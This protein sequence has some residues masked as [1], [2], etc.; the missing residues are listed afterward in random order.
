MTAP[1]FGRR[2]KAREL[3]LQALYLMDMR[4]LD[5]RQAIALVL[6]VEERVPDD[7]LVFFRRLVEG[8]EEHLAE[9]DA[10]IAGRLENWAIERLSTVDR[11]ILRLA[12]EEILRH[13]DIPPLVSVNEAIEIAKKYGDEKSGG[14]INGILDTFLR[15]ED[16]LSEN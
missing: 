14:F 4:R 2:R 6:E 11:N 15:P 7:V 9:I 12:V 3:A 1:R 10:D 16:R 13:K 5:A 8:V